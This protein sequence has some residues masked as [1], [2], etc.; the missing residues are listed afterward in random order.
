MSTRD[1]RLLLHFECLVAL[2]E[3]QHFGKAARRIG[4]SQP[5]FS[6][7]IKAL[8]TACGTVIIKRMRR[9]AGL[10]P[11][12]EA[13]LQHARRIV[14]DVE[15]FR[16][17]IGDRLHGEGAMLR[18]GSVPSTLVIAG[19][20]TQ[21]LHKA[22]AQINVA[23]Q[24][25]STPDLQRMVQQDQL[26]GAI[27][28][29]TPERDDDLLVTT[30]YREC[31]DL[32]VPAKWAAELPALMSWREID[33]MPL[34][35]LESGF[36]FRAIVDEA[37]AAAGVRPRVTLESNSMAALVTQATMGDCAVIV[38]HSFVETMPM[39]DGV[40]VIALRPPKVGHSIG[41]IVHRTRADTAFGQA[42][43]AIGESLRDSLRHPV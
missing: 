37:C 41:L 22:Y 18:L 33:G 31:Y 13:V 8:E 24:V 27:C 3:T 15:R 20:L 19:R 43:V 32:V 30:L 2:S 6:Q 23:V 34:G 29:V 17:A 38:P 36:H 42:L 5:A 12:G 9:Y 25:A 11:D 21:E 4:L 16:L 1:D 35:L 7:A 14:E 10:T 28:Y 40:R 26:S 39:P